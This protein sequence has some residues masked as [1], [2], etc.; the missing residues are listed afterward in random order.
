MDEMTLGA[1]ISGGRYDGKFAEFIIY[2]SDQ[3][4]NRTAIETNINDHYNIY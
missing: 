3:S 2:P 4:A 1:S